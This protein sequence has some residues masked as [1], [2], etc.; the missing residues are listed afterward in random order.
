MSY[1]SFVD[2]RHGALIAPLL[3][4]P[5]TIARMEALSRHGTPAIAA[6]DAS[7]PRDLEL[8]NTER[9]YVGRWIRD[10]LSARG[11]R[12]LRQRR[13]SGGRVFS[14]GTVYVRARPVNEVPLPDSLPPPL[15][16]IEDGIAQ[17]RLMIAEFST[18][19]YGVAE[20]LRDKRE[21]ARRETQRY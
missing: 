19:D 21:E 17:A 16:S 4:D 15:L 10:I 13:F 18:N 1:A 3:S 8:N 14:S 12:T 5:E 20:Y 7:L 11:W 6:L 2:S 9:Q